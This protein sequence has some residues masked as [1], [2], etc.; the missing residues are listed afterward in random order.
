MSGRFR[1]LRAVGQA[2]ATLRSCLCDEQAT[3]HLDRQGQ[4]DAVVA[5]CRILD[6]LEGILSAARCPACG[7]T[8]DPCPGGSGRPRTYCDARCRRRERYRRRYVQETEYQRRYWVLHGDRKR[9]VGRIVT[10]Y[11]HQ[12]VGTKHDREGQEL[13]DRLP[14]SWE[15]DPSVAAERD[16]LASIL[17][18]IVGDMDESGVAR[19]GPEEL[20][21]LRRRL[22]AAGVGA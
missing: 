6:D 19:L 16:E 10:L 20:L 1:A 11:L 22:I 17:R 9:R 14:S 5:V 4:R 7:A 2:S 18:S 15:D 12:R 8:F 21:K 3:I 13:V